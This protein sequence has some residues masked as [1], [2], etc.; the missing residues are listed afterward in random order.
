MIKGEK[1]FEKT[2]YLCKVIKKRNPEK[3]EI[4][5]LLKIILFL[6]TIFPENFYS[7]AKFQKRRSKRFFFQIYEKWDKFNDI[8]GQKSH[9]VAK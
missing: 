6:N 9:K 2:F 5:I 8:P 7:E 4:I 1:L 3:K